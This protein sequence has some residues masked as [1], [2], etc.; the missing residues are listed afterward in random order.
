MLSRVPTPKKPRKLPPRGAQGRFIVDRKK[1]LR[2]DPDWRASLDLGDS[3]TSLPVRRGTLAKNAAEEWAERLPDLAI[4]E[5][6]RALNE[7]TYAPVAPP[8]VV[9]AISRP[10][11]RVPG[12]GPPRRR[13]VT[14]LREAT[15]NAALLA[16]G[17]LGVGYAISRIP[18]K[19]RQ[20]SSR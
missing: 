2:N 14:P 20:G 8:P 13:P 4:W 18:H 15:R 5:R 11:P 16:L 1:A 9:E 3:S 7:R 6:R 19:G 12:L 17:A 10:E